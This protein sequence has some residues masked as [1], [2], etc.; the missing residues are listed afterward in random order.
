MLISSAIGLQGF[1]LPGNK[2]SQA[3]CLVFQR[4]PMFFTSLLTTVKKKYLIEPI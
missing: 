3:K 2:T 1:P 4:L